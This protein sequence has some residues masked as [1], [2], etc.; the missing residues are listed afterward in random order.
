MQA[1]GYRLQAT[2]YRLQTTSYRLRTTDYRLQVT[3]YRLQAT[4]YRLH[5]GKTNAWSEKVSQNHCKTNNFHQKSPKTIVK[6]IKTK[7]T[8]K[9]SK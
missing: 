5:H 1:T 7:K 9:S 6:P 3:D 2:G 8:K 4:D